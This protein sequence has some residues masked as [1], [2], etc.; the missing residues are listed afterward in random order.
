MRHAIS[1]HV[2]AAAI[3]ISSV[4]VASATAFDVVKYAGAA[5]LIVVGVRRLLGRDDAARGETRPSGNLRRDYRQGVVVNVL[6]PKTALFILAR[7]SRPRSS[8]SV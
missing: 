8:C 7:A 1:V 6:N 3:G 2:T 5:Y 4:L